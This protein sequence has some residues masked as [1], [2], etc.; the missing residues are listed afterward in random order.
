MLS[1]LAAN[2]AIPTPTSAVSKHI[3]SLLEEQRRIRAE[4]AAI[5]KELKNAQRRRARLKFKA[6][7]LTPAD[8]A[9]VLV[10]RQEEE[11][12]RAQT[13]KRRRSS[14]P[15]ARAG[16]GED[17]SSGIDALEPAERGET[18]V[19]EEQVAGSTAEPAA[20]T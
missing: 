15:E 11:E 9:S 19:R 8:L 20:L 13:A 7:L 17:V 4:K 18:E 5:A 6:R 14:Q 10:L 12:T 16:G 3:D 2:E 1:A